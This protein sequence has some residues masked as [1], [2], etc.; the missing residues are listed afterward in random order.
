MKRIF[1]IVSLFSLAFV[2]T[3]TGFSQI[4]TA[5]CCQQQAACCQHGACCHKTAVAAKT[6][7]VPTDSAKR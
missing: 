2:L 5:Q 6:A 1:S 4:P 7:A 3:G